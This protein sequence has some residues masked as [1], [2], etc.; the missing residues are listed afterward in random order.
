[1]SQTL[2]LS[3]NGHMDDSANDVCDGSTVPGTAAHDEYS[4][5]AVADSDDGGGAG[6]AGSG[7]SS[8]DTLGQASIHHSWLSSATIQCFF[9]IRDESI[10]S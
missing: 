2:M 7:H 6:A 1:M 8:H 5:A 3:G 9:Y 4:N 10:I